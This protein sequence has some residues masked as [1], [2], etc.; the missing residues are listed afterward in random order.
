MQCDVR[1]GV[2]NRNLRREGSI[3]SRC[4]VLSVEGLDS[5]V[6]DVAGTLPPLCRDR[7]NPWWP[8]QETTTFL[9]IVALF[10][11]DGS[12]MSIYAGYQ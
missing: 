11:Q 8:W 2:Y 12:S 1:R 4:C 3:V 7:L 9:H 10:S 5:R 6:I